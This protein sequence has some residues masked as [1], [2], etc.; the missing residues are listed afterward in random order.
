MYV[1][2]VRKLC[3]FAS[4][5]YLLNPDF[6]VQHNGKNNLKKIILMLYIY[7]PQDIC[8]YIIHF[9]LI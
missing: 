1:V 5:G 7:T 9:S 2:A 8:P 6:K 4:D 3:K